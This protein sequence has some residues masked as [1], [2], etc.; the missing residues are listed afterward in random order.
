MTR[1]CSDGFSKGAQRVRAFILDGGQAV[2]STSASSA[3]EATSVED[4]CA[5]VQSVFG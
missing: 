2:S 3:A 5:F 4:M 1:A